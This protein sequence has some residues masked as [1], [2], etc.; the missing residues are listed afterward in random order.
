MEKRISVVIP[1]RNEEEL[2]P[3]CLSALRRQEADEF[4]IVVVDSASTDRTREVAQSFGA[5]VIRLNEPGVARARQAGFEAATGDIIVSTD[6][7][8]VCQPDWLQKITE[9]FR[10]QDIVAVFGTIELDGKSIWMRLGRNVYPWFQAIN[11]KMGH[12][13]FCGPNFAVTKDIFKKVDGFR[14][15]GKYPDEAEDVL[16]AH[17]IKTKGKIV[18]L[19]DSRVIVSSRRLDNGQGLHYTTH[20]F[21]VYLNVCWFTRTK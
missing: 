1:A 9:P 18:F 10:N 16:F 13:L 17:K 5:R 14:I 3:G 21:G 11:I 20:H 4:E 15:N 7:D 12:P 2:L 6:A 19:P 8:A